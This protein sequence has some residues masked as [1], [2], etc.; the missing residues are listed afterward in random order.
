MAYILLGHACKCSARF[1]AASKYYLEAEKVAKSNKLGIDL[2]TCAFVYQQL[3]TYKEGRNSEALKALLPLTE[4]NS[5]SESTKGEL[6]QLLGNIYRSAA[7][8][9]KAENHF[10]ES[11]SIAQAENVKDEVKL[12][13]RMG[14][15]GQVYRSRGQ[16]PEALACQKRYYDFAFDRGDVAGIAAACSYIGFTYYTQ[17]EYSKAIEYLGVCYVLSEKIGDQFG[18]RCCYNN[19]GKVY[20]ELGHADDALELFEESAKIAIE[21]GDLL[22]EGTSYGNMG[23]T[24]RSAGRLE[25]AIRCHSLYLENAKLRLDTG[26]VAIMQNELALDYLR[27]GNYQEATKFAWLALN[28]SLEIRSWLTSEDDVA[29]IANHEKNQATSY[30]IL[31]YVLVERVSFDAALLVSDMGRARALADKLHNVNASRCTSLPALFS[32]VGLIDDCGNVN[33][34]A[35]SENM[36]RL[37]RLLDSLQS[38]LIVYSLIDYP[39]LR[40]SNSKWLYIWLVKCSGEVHFH[41]KHLQNMNSEEFAIDHGYLVDLHNQLGIRDAGF[42]S[43]QTVVNK[44]PFT[45]ERSAASGEK[46]DIVLD[47]NCSDFVTPVSMPPDKLVQLYT[48]LVEPIQTSFIRNGGSLQTP[49]AV[50]IPHSVLFNIPFAALRC[51]DGEYL[52]QKLALSVAPSIEVLYISSCIWLRMLQM[53]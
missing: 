24:Y 50:I 27:L 41:K 16:F 48:R 8:Y 22:G 5:L 18:M 26:G 1:S 14:E 9:H 30:V 20:H 53:R 44:A 38:D 34:S 43:S 39:L 19:I 35:V 12:A 42:T 49:R 28:T 6:H 23:T 31:Q 52:V 11:I 4:R 7:N 47:D 10:K 46:R 13:E 45:V 33:Q 3:C 15:L 17:K 37:R 36:T 2:E 29:K 51:P 40:S 21:L 32:M 25:D